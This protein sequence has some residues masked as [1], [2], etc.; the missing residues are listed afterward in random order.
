[1]SR[2]RY[3]EFRQNIRMGSKYKYKY[4]GRCRSQHIG[5]LVDLEK[6]LEETHKMNDAKIAHGEV[7]A[8]P[9]KKK[10]PLGLI[11]DMLSAGKVKSSIKLGADIVSAIVPVIEEP[12]WWN[13]IRSAFAVG[14]LAIDRMEF[15]SDDYFA[16]DEWS[17]PYTRDFNTLVL[18]A[19]SGFPYETIRSSDEM[20]VIRSIDLDGIKIAYPYNINLKTVSNVYVE[21]Q[22]LVEAKQKI[23]GLLWEMY[24]NTN[25]V[26]RQN[27]RGQNSD[28]ESTVAFESDDAFVSMTSRRASEYSAYLKRC[29]DAGVNRSV[30]LYGPPGTGKSTMARTIID[31]LGI[32]SFRIRV[33]D[34]ASLE[35]ST[36]FEAINIFEPDAIILDDFD[37]AHSQA[38]LL[39]TLEFFQRHVK[40]VI[41]TVNDRNSLDEA[42]MRPGR[43][44]ELIFVKSMEKDVVMSI[45]G[46]K[47]K[48]AY[49][50][51][52]DW[53]VAFIQEY[54]KRRKFM[55]SEEAK[56]S[57][58]ELAMRVKRLEKYDD[59]NEVERMT[60]AISEKSLRKK[61]VSP[62]D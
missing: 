36:L 30:L 8:G 24:K 33:E 42:I 60:K 52:K 59:E 54:V 43:F 56:S 10:S 25:L 35:S 7:S 14:K 40:L 11:K 21:T 31:T 15:W 58:V 38:Q 4:N 19:I 50:S 57:T 28:I 22:H 13:G 62:E 53:P 61:E 29:I 18:K 27:K 1:M 23:K 9:E 55:S 5:N 49:E 6:L 16:G 3:I 48:D 17:I 51:V 44:D 41:A 45:L 2:S 12:N 47:H 32:R 20:I 34:V 26:M 46:P 39:E 37:R